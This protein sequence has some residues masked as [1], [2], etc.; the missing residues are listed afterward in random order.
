[1]IDVGGNYSTVDC[2]LAAISA[3]IFANNLPSNGFRLEAGLVF[4]LGKRQ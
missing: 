3:H 1:M 2:A 4:T